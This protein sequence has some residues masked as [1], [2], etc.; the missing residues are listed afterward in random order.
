MKSN[1][2][3]NELASRLQS[4]VPRWMASVFSTAAEEPASPEHYDLDDLVMQRGWW[5]E[6]NVDYLRTGEKPA[7]DWT[8]PSFFRHPQ[9]TTVLIP[10]LKA[11]VLHGSLKNGPPSDFMDAVDVAIGFLPHGVR[12]LLAERGIGLK[13]GRIMTDID[14]DYA[15]AQCRGQDAKAVNVTGIYEFA[16]HFAAVTQGY[17]S[18]ESGEYVEAD[19]WD[20][21]DSVLHEYAHALEGMIFNTVI[22][23]GAVKRMEPMQR[24]FIHAYREDVAALNGAT[25]F[26]NLE[27][28]LTY[29][30][31][32]ENGGTHDTEEAARSEAFAVLFAEKYADLNNIM[33]QAFPRTLQAIEKIVASIEALV[34]RNPSYGHISLPQPLMGAALQRLG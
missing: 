17:I 11:P 4:M 18:S 5:R 29:C 31:T 33:Q 23:F 6:H 9:L 34:D 8:P 22:S 12:T 7:E 21:I 16:K 24:D 26:G 27:T 28:S 25:V 2:A 32:K 19:T 3:V 20:I 14:A 13:L 30:L 10:R 15:T 1:Q